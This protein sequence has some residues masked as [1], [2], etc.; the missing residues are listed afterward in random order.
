MLSEPPFSP[1]MRQQ[2]VVQIASVLST[3]ALCMIVFRLVDEEL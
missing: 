2:V 3:D 1:V